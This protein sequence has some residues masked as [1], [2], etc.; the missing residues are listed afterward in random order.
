M[1]NF[2]QYF[3]SNIVNDIG[4][5]DKDMQKT[6]ID[7]LKDVLNVNAIRKSQKPAPSGPISPGYYGGQVTSESLQKEVR[8]IIRE[9]L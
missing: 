9:N 4:E 1:N 6:I 8:K 5:P 7:K 3:V 2:A